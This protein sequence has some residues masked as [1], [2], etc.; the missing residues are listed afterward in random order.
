MQLDAL[1]GEDR[2]GGRPLINARFGYGGQWG[3]NLFTSRAMLMMIP[4]EA[5]RRSPRLTSTFL[6]VT[7][8]TGVSAAIIPNAGQ[9][10]HGLCRGTGPSEDFAFVDHGLATE[11]NA[12]RAVPAK[13]EKTTGCKA[14]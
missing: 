7:R 6:T 3:R 4:A 5:R 9:N 10:Q 13:L 1:E 11:Q 12:D 8:L 2:T 14:R